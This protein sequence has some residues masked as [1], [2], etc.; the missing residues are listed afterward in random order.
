MIPKNNSVEM[1]AGT[2]FNSLL[3]VFM[4]ATFFFKVMNDNLHSMSI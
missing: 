2:F 3:I 4:L 1:F